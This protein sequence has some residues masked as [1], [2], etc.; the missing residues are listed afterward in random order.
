ML[1]KIIITGINTVKVDN[2]NVDNS[3]YDLTGRKADVRHGLA[4]QRMSNGTVRKVIRR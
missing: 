1:N 3:I 2:K 4:I